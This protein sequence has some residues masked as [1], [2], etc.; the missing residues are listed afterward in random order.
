MF[1]NNADIA[2]K[3]AHNKCKSFK[4]IENVAIRG[5]TC[6]GSYDSA[7]ITRQKN[8]SP[9]ILTMAVE[10]VITAVCSVLDLM[11]KNA[12]DV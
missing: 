7:V 12:D 6:D 8:F 5:W 1:W 11:T 9:V 10:E 3:L 4:Q 2:S